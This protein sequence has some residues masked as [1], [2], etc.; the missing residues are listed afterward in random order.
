[1]LS[2]TTGVFSLSVRAAGLMLPLAL[3]LSCSSL[4]Y[5]RT[6]NLDGARFVDRLVLTGQ[7]FRLERSSPAGNVVYSG[8]FWIK[9]GIWT[10]AISSL[11]GDSGLPH[12]LDPQM[13]FICKGRRFDNGVAFFATSASRSVQQDIF[14]S[15]PSDFDL[16]R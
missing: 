2:R 12:R 1:M 14:L 7:S 15:L 4:R 16:E 6:G 13:L 3:L 5:V 11:R 8:R 10:F 9:D